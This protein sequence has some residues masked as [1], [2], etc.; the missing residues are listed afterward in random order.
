[1]DSL[2][3]LVATILGTIIF[4]LLNQAVSITYLGCQSMIFVWLICFLI[5]FVLVMFFGAIFLKVLKW[6]IILAIGIF[7]ISIIISIIGIIVNKI[8]GIE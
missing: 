4:I 2:V 5:A 3:G 7:A 8:K 6:A 1:M